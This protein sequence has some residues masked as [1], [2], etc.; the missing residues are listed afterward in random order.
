MNAPADK[1]ERHPGKRD[2]GNQRHVSAIEMN[3][4]RAPP[5]AHLLRSRGPC[6]V[7]GR[8][9]S[10]IIHTLNHVQRS[11]A[12]PHVEHEQIEPVRSVFAAAP[13]VTDGY[14]ARTVVGELPIVGS[15]APADH[16]QP[17]FVFGMLLRIARAER[18]RASARQ[19]LAIQASAASGSKARQIVAVGN[20][21]AA[22]V[23]AAD[24]C[25]I[26]L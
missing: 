19:V 16:R 4:H 3:D 17:H 5:I 15:V 8:I 14:A 12:R 23:A 13:S 20:P 18:R 26:R 22:A 10:V 7:V 21:L 9:A 11:R 1:R 25:G 24:P 2:G 6:A